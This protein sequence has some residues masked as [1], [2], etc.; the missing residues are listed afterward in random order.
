MSGPETQGR[1][2]VAEDLVGRSTR[3][4]ATTTPESSAT[5]WTS[6]RL[7]LKVFNV[8]APS[9]SDPAKGYTDITDQID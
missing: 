5:P 2:G 6:Y 4:P 7:E 3:W 1:D 9:P 8:T